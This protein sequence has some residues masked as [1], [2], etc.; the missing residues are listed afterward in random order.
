MAEFLDV[1]QMLDL[2]NEDLD[3]EL[4][5]LIAEA[6]E[7]IVD[8]E[9]QPEY[10]CPVLYLGWYWRDI[11]RF[12]VIS[13]TKDRLWI[14]VPKKWGYPSSDPI[15]EEGAEELRQKVREICLKI[16]D[17]GRLI[18]AHRR[19]FREFLEENYGDQL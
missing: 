7:I 15:G 1:D 9:F 2:Q 8:Q 19:E 14:N 3:R 10:K 12:T 11:D 4:Y 17:R 18:E 13:K 5:E 6:E 16:I